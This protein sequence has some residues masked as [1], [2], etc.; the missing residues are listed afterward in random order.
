MAS[1]PLLA[2]AA[3]LQAIEQSQRA[4]KGVERA[5]CEIS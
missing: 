2:V 5:T 1:V 3:V 4:W